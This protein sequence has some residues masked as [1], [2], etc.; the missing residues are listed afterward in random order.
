MKNVLLAVLV[1]VGLG[2]SVVAMADDAATNQA[3]NSSM[4]T[5]KPCPF[6]TCES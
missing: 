3:N 2:S 4:F 5:H 6:N 1:L